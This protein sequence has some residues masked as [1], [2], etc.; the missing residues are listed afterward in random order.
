MTREKTLNLDVHFS[1][2]KILNLVISH[3]EFP[4]KHRENSEV[5]ITGRK[6]IILS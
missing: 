3:R 2:P 1:G 4:S 6:L 5:E